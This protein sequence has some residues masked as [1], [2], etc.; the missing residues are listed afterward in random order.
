MSLSSELSLIYKVPILDSLLAMPDFLKTTE[1]AQKLLSLARH[2]R[3]QCS[4]Q[5]CAAKYAMQHSGLHFHEQHA[6]KEAANYAVQQSKLHLHEQHIR[7][8]AAQSALQQSL[9]QLDLTQQESG[10]AK[11]E[12]WRA[13][14]VVGSMRALI[15]GLNIPF[16]SFS[17]PN[18]LSEVPCLPQPYSD[19]Q[20]LPDESEVD[21]SETELDSVV[22]STRI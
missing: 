10:K 15:H 13:N 2:H 20:S 9:V 18:G 8:E 14:Q 7:E 1:D 4:A 19:A 3:D 5:K 21:E 12:L 6:Q 11:G 22:I 16:E 17:V